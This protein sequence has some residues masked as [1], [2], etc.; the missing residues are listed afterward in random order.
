MKQADSKDKLTAS[1]EDYAFAVFNL[2]GNWVTRV[3]HDTKKMFLD[4]RTSR[5]VMNHL[6]SAVTGQMNKED[7]RLEFTL[8]IPFL[9]VASIDIQANQALQS[10]HTSIIDRM[11][12]LF[13]WHFPRRFKSTLDIPWFVR[14]VQERDVVLNEL[15]QSGDQPPSSIS[16]LD[17]AKLLLLRRFNEY[18][19]LYANDLQRMTQQGFIASMPKRVYD[20]LSGVDEKNFT[21]LKFSVLMWAAVTSF[22]DS[23]SKKIMS[24]VEIVADQK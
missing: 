14:D 21:S 5:I 4:M 9:A 11:L 16:V 1:P 24:R 12:G 10:S 2:A 19:S 7:L 13:Y 20:H 22:S 15:K 18:R 17:M 3:A 23:L 6:W 8:M